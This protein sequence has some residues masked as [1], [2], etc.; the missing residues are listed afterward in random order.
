M[1][2]TMC[3]RKKSLESK[4]GLGAQMHTKQIMAARMVRPGCEHCALAVRALRCVVA[5]HRPCRRLWPA[6][7]QACCAVSRSCLDVSWPLLWRYRSPW[8]CCIVPHPQLDYPLVMIQRLYRDTIPP[9]TSTL[10]S[11]HK[12]NCIVTHPQ[13]VKLPPVT[14]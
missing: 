14:I 10:L 7:S 9:A 1:T 3:M 5:Q 6:M 4:T 12:G 2:E 13:P 11:R 8:L